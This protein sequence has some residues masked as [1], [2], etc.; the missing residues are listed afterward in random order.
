MARPLAMIASAAAWILLLLPVQARQAGPDESAPAEAPQPPDAPAQAT[1]ETL[2]TARKVKERASDV[3]GSVSAVSSSLLLDA[4][5]TSVR[6]AS[7]RVPNLLMTEFTSR[8]LSFPFLRGIGS[9]QGEPGVVTYVDG[10]PQLTTGSTNL[11]L[12]GLERVEFLRGPQ[13]TLYGRNSLGG[14]LHLI[15]APPSVRHELDASATLGSYDQQDFGLS[16]SGP[17]VPGELS[18]GVSGLYSARDGY[19][20]NRFS[21]NDVDSRESFF[22]RVQALWTPGDRDEV[23]FS[24]HGERARDGGFALGLVSE[25]LHDPRRID[26]DFEGRVD[27]DIVAPSLTWRRFGDSIDFTSITAYETWDAFESSDFDFSPV[28][29]VVRT[30]TEGQDYVYQELRL[31]SAQGRPIP[32]S[33]SADLAWLGGLSLFYANSERSAVNDVHNSPIGA[34]VQTSSG[35]FEDLGLG[36]FGQATATLDERLDLTAG[37]RFDTELKQADL[38]NTSTLGGSV[39]V[40]DSLEEDFSRAVPQLSAAYR[41][42]QGCMLYGSVSMGYKAGGFNLSSGEG[43][44]A[45]GPE[46]TVSYELGYKQ[47]L[48]RERLNLRL[49]LFYV[50]WRD[51]QLT[52]FDP[53][54]GGIVDNAGQSSSQGV[55]LELDAR[56]TEHLT[57]F[58]AFGSA[59]ATFDEYSPAP[60]I[61]LAGKRL[62]FAPETT[63][64]LAAQY[65][66]ELASRSRWFLRGEYV[67]IGEFFYDAA[68]RGSERYD[69]ASFRAGVERGPLRL[70]TWIKNAFDEVYVPI[71]FPDPSGSGDF[72]GENGAPMTWGVTLRGSW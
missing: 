9:G 62:P 26:Q 58:T 5:L 42:A 35:D 31:S 7:L 18:L 15:S 72:I 8:R 2:V 64:S 25:L 63:W 66:G 32:L 23:R 38:R 40:S 1:E 16:W 4:G 54:A 27:R 37:V 30:T 29:G 65:G 53:L 69:L 36:L 60:G 45:F 19:T 33:A 47:A 6:D 39:D 67:M 51:M 50:D 13:G 10:V 55:E 46:T 52:V 17:V 21:G 70:E 41:P 12:F 44:Y 56:V 14:V 22:G 68:N 34:G 43:D 57:L 11:P 59:D 49:A 61:D 24:L 71:A 28:D 20:T 3:P 48:W